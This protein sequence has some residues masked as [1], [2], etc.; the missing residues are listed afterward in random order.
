MSVKT[1]RSLKGGSSTVSNASTT[2]RYQ[3]LQE[4]EFVLNPDNPIK[5]YTGPVIDTTDRSL[6]V[7]S[8]TARFDPSGFRFD[9]P[10]AKDIFHA[11]PYITCANCN[12]LSFVD[13]V[14]IRRMLSLP[15]A[16]SAE[17]RLAPEILPPCVRCNCADSFVVGSHD[18]AAEV[19]ERKR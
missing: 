5:L 12:Y 14:T 18:F 2:S 17:L 10:L 7:Y 8:K 11:D 3:Q 6:V 19:E 16:V 13:V 15:A 9:R 4:E 1:V